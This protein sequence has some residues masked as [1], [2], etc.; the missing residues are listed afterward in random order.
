M[1]KVVGWNGIITE[2]E[3]KTKKKKIRKLQGEAI[4][5][6]KGRLHLLIK[7]CILCWVHLVELVKYSPY[8][9]VCEIVD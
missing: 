3:R 1:R 2:K 4:V 9:F 5:L 8:C 7:P 6:A